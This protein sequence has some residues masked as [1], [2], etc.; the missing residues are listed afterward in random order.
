M[1]TYRLTTLDDGKYLKEWLLQ[2][3]VQEGF[4]MSTPSEVDD[5]VSRWISF[6]P[7]KAS[8]TALDD[9]KPVGLAT[10]YLNPYKKLVHQ[11]ECGILV[12]TDFQ[13]RGIGKGLMKELFSLA[14]TFHIELLSL[15]V[16]TH[17]QRAIKLYEQFGFKTFAEQTHWLKNEEGSYGGR[18]LMECPVE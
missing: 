7:Y 18:L 3:G 1:I 16:Q 9:E 15:Q 4:P 8:V 12:A 17:N 11:C 14:K 6:A 5:A 10:L 2:E 13:S